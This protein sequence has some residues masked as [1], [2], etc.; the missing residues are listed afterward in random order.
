[1]NCFIAVKEPGDILEEPS[2]SQIISNGVGMTQVG[3]LVGVGVEIQDCKICF[4]KAK[5]RSLNEEA[6]VVLASSNPQVELWERNKSEAAETTEY[7]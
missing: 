3:E 7:C 2:K 5:Y 6:I 1:M 4:L